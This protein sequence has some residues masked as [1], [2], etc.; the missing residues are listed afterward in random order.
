MHM[1][2]KRGVRIDPLWN[3]VTVGGK[4]L[5]HGKILAFEPDTNEPKALWKSSDKA[6]PWSGPHGN[7][8]DLDAGGKALAYGHGLYQLVICDRNLTPLETWEPR[9][10]GHEV[11]SARDFGA[12]GAGDDSIDRDT[13][14]LQAAVDHCIRTGAKL[15]IPAG[16]Y[17]LTESL[18][19]YRLMYPHDGSPNSGRGSGHNLD[20]RVFAPCQIEIMGERSAYGIQGND[21]VLIAT[22]KDRPAIVIQGASGAVLS[23]LS[24]EGLNDYPLT[25]DPDELLDDATFVV[26]GCRDGDNRRPAGPGNANHSPYAGVAIDPYGSGGPPADG[27]Y[28]G[29]EVDYFRNGL[30]ST[31]VTLEQCNFYRFVVGVLVSPSG[32]TRRCEGITLSD[33]GFEHHK[34]SVAVCQGTSSGVV[35]RNVRSFGNLFFVSTSS[36]GDGSPSAEAPSIRGASVSATKHL[37][38]VNAPDSAAIVEGLSCESTLG[39]GYIES[40]YGADLPA[41]TLVGCNFD[42]VHTS[43]ALDTHLASSASVRFVGCTFASSDRQVPIRFFNSGPLAFASCAFLNAPSAAEA[44]WGRAHAPDPSEV[45]FVGFESLEKVTFEECNVGERSLPSQV[46][47]LDRVHR[48]SRISSLNRTYV[49]PGSLIVAADMSGAPLR[50]SAQARD[51]AMANVN[52]SRDPRAPGE[53][54]FHAPDPSVLKPGDLVF[55]Q[56]AGFVPEHY[57]AGRRSRGVCGVIKSIAGGVV[58]LG[59]VVRSLPNGRLDLAVKYFPRLHLPSTGTTMAGSDV[60]HEVTNARTW[61]QFDRI[62]GT[63]IAEGAYVLDPVMPGAT[64]L[65]I[66]K[67]A[68]AS[69]NVRLYDADI[70]RFS[71]PRG[72]FLRVEA[73]PSSRVDPVS[74]RAER[75][76][77]P[78][79]KRLPQ[80]SV[81]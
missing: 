80:T 35:L 30:A 67:P 64:R 22:F 9:F 12:V 57:G 2:L 75:A 77:P 26:A 60:L 44:G 54:T 66:S 52:V 40:A 10:Y 55:V 28:P 20:R 3:G 78:S 46:M 70:A 19:V 47:V 62:S 74:S 73:P 21:T 34:I 14:A 41:L 39:L 79:T 51:I 68:V 32:S 11:V 33:C 6:L 76:E 59:S 29:H 1:T 48:T 72:T 50:V 65:R 17:K 61:R 7:Q 37:F 4:P 56:G 15:F 63:G 23:R 24:V 53:A 49:L 13:F 45:C 27:G 36:Y 16:A 43:P 8:V 31:G 18:C 25:G 71:E 38:Y 42:L 81:R 58:R 5:A 69:G